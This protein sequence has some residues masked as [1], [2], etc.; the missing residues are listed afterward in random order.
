LKSIAKESKFNV[1]YGAGCSSHGH[2]STNNEEATTFSGGK[3]DDEIGGKP[4]AGPIVGVTIDSV[5]VRHIVSILRPV[6]EDGKIVFVDSTVGLE[7]LLTAADGR[8]ETE[9]AGQVCER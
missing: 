3:F 6:E 1:Q 2:P 4:K 8:G 7:A 5:W 9:Y